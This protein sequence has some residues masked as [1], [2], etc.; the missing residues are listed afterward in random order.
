MRQL[1]PHQANKVELYK[2]PI[3]LFHRYQVES[4]FDAMHSPVVQLRTGGY[5][6]INPTEALGAIDVN[7]GRPA[8]EPHIH[9]TAPPTNLRPP[10]NAP[11]HAP[12]PPIPA[13]PQLP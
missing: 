6:V 9:D 3:P 4:Q 7:S 11:P 10:Q 2:E 13:P 12:L 8:K 5:I 1:V